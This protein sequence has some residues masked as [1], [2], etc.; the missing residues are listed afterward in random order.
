MEDFY[1]SFENLIDFCK[2]VSRYKQDGSKVLNN[3]SGSIHRTVSYFST[4]YQEARKKEEEKDNNRSEEE[5]KNNSK[6]YKSLLNIYNNVKKGMLENT[7]IDKLMSYFNPDRKGSYSMNVTYEG[8]SNKLRLPLSIVYRKCL[9]VS[10]EVASEKKEN[11]DDFSKMEFWTEYFMYFLLKVF[12]NIASI[13]KKIE[14][15]DKIGTFVN[16]LTEILVLE[17]EENINYVDDACNMFDIIGDFT[18]EVGMKVPKQMGAITRKDQKDA[19]IQLK[20]AAKD[21][22]TK[23]AVNKIFSGINLETIDSVGDIPE[24]FERIAKALKDNASEE[25]D[26]IKKANIATANNPDPE[27]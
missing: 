3:D 16:E 15:R 7:K 2:E 24:V 1:K 18:N 11:E 19:M 20:K 13:E 27:V 6:H 10:V 25:P 14:E 26:A 8:G 4:C 5:K 21:P 17:D 12:Y 9:Q 23:Q 22:K